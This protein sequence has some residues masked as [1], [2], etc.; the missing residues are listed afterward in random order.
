MTRKNFMIV[1][2]TFLKN[3]P[4]FLGRLDS[5]RINKT[6]L[7]KNENNLPLKQNGTNIII[8]LMDLPLTL[9]MEVGV[10]I[11]KLSDWMLSPQ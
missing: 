4:Y 6:K 1:E 3:T 2:I 10:I 7:I 5:W 11:T 8:I 9:N